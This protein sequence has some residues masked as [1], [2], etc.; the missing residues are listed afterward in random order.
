MRGLCVLNLMLTIKDISI[1]MTR[2]VNEA[3]MRLIKDTYEGKCYQLKLIHSVNRI[4]YRSNIMANQF[5]LNGT[6]NTNVIIEA[7]CECYTYQEAVM[8][9]TVVKVS[10]IFVL[11]SDNA[12]ALL[13]PIEGIETKEGDKLPIKVGKAMMN[14]GNSLIK[15]NALP[16]IPTPVSI[17]LKLAYSKKSKPDAISALNIA[18][19]NYANAMSRISD[20]DTFTQVATN[21]YPYKS[22]HV[23]PCTSSHNVTIESLVKKCISGDDISKL[24]GVMLYS[25][26]KM[27][28]G[29]RKQGK[30][31]VIKK[32]DNDCDEAVEVCSVV[33]GLIKICLVETLWVSEIVEAIESKL[34]ENTSVMS[35]YDKYKK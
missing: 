29:L 15:I 17:V 4:L 18:M 14:I 7:D 11:R 2:D 19:T 33:D 32:L 1:L 35:L 31:S 25:G 10:D 8:S 12:I 9:M 5:D 3:I 21:L 23:L 24:D 28:I 30:V 27:D 20:T 16:Y 26:D 22:K 13:R 34:I 6:F